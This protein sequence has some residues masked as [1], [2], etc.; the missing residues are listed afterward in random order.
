MR[1]FV[2]ALQKNFFFNLWIQVYLYVCM[3]VQYLQEPEEGIVSSG[4][5]VTGSSEVDVSVLS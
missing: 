1:V 4:V 5:E 2:S 3:W